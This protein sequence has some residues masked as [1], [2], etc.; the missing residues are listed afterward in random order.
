MAFPGA[1]AGTGL[2][3]DLMSLRQAPLLPPLLLVL[4]TY[5]LV[6]QDVGQPLRAGHL[7]A[8]DLTGPVSLGNLAHCPL[9]GHPPSHEVRTAAL[10]TLLSHHYTYA[11]VPP[12]SPGTAALRGSCLSGKTQ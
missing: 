10:R 12:V 2:G 9:A 3:S 7:T 8:R 6:A 4:S 1:P 11:A 5:H